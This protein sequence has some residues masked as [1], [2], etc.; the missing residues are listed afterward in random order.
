MDA[1]ADPNRATEC[2]NT[3]LHKAEMFGHKKVA[4]LLQNAG[5]DPKAK[6]KHGKTP[7]QMAEDRGKMKKK[8]KYAYVRECW[9]CGSII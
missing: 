6:N 5:A 3:P 7:H 1:G 9:M 2:G 4:K 8:E